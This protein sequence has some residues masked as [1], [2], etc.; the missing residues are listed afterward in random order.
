MSA[1]RSEFKT[2][3]EESDL[4]QKRLLTEI[5]FLKKNNL[6]TLEKVMPKTPFDEQRDLENFE[7]NL[8]NSTEVAVQLVSCHCL[9][10][11]LNI[12]PFLSTGRGNV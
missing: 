7:Q 3:R 9:I 10:S 5:L 1:L 12:K 2:F 4:T 6:N 11:F 8:N